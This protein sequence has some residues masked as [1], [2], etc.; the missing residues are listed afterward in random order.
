MG[1]A[2]GVRFSL[3]QFDK[4]FAVR[5][6]NGLPYVLI[7][8]QAVN[9]WAERYLLVEPSLQE[10]LPFTSE[11]IDFKGGRD[12]VKRIAAQLGLVP[13]FP[14]RVEMTAL[15]GVIPFRVGDLTANIEVV[16]QIPGVSASIE[17]LAIEAE[18]ASRKIR[19]L[20]PISLLASKLELAANTSQKNRRDGEHLKILVPCVRAFLRE[21][22]QQAKQ[23]TLPLSGWLGAAN[24]VMTLTSR[25]RS[26]TLAKRLGISWHNLLPL[27]DIIRS[28]NEKLVRFREIRLRRWRAN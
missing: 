15:A 8:G 26:R 12:D 24:K 13:R 18:W 21:F 20:D 25:A 10:L 22:L 4:V 2:L 1:L 6:S 17:A 28:D 27:D 9:Y 19:V 11:D 16:R 23:D 7:G 5:N 3:Q 14:H